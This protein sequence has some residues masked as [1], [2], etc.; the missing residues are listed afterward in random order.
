MAHRLLGPTPSLAPE[1]SP[2]P[3]GGGRPS[4]GAG[5]TPLPAFTISRPRES[6]H[7][8]LQPHK[9]SRETSRSDP[10]VASRHTFGAAPKHSPTHATCAVGNEGNESLCQT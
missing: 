1:A 3:E 10:G 2:N 7:Y 9:R 6:F 5:E 4:S 8:R